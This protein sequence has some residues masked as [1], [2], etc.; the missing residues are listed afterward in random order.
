MKKIIRRSSKD[1]GLSSPNLYDK[2][3]RCQLDAFAMVLL[4]QLN[5]DLGVPMNDLLCSY[6]SMVTGKPVNDDLNC[7]NADRELEYVIISNGEYLYHSESRT[8]YTYS[9]N[10]EKIGIY[11]SETESIILFEV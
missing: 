6:V 1:T 3:N 10:P 4:K 8:V 2:V 9:D 11:D 5:Q 7:N